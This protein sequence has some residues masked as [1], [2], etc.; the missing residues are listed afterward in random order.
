MAN[1]RKKKRTVSQPISSLSGRQFVQWI[2]KAAI[3]FFFSAGFAVKM[4]YPSPDVTEKPV[5]H[6]LKWF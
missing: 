2:V 4:G 3:L 6:I 1:K 5:R